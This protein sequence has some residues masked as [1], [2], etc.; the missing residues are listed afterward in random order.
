M[1]Q[2]IQKATHA[3]LTKLF[4]PEISIPDWLHRPGRPESGGQWAPVQ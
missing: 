2:V 3:V 4:D 1:T